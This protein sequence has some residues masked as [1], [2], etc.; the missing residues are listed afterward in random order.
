MIQCGKRLVSTFRQHSNALDI[1]Y[2]SFESNEISSQVPN[3]GS[4][5]MLS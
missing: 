4:D 5:G 1:S 3:K 2:A